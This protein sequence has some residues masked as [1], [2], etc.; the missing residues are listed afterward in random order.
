[1]KRTGHYDNDKGYQIGYEDGIAE[2]RTV[3]SVVQCVICGHKKDPCFEKSEEGFLCTREKGHLLPHIACAFGR[4]SVKTWFNAIPE[5][6]AV[7][8]KKKKEAST[9]LVGD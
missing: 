7:E 5:W 9:G 8:D 4:H 6:F 3:D 1:M 2:A